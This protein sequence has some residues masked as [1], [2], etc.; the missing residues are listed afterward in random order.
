VAVS[1]ADISNPYNTVTVQERVVEQTAK[2]AGERID[3][4]AKKHLRVDKYPCHRP[5]EKRILLKIKPENVFY[6]KPA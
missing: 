4:M 1:V 2:G 5:G 6:Q 3:K